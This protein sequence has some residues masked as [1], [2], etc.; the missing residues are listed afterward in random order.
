[1][2]SGGSSS[3]WIY[4]GEYIGGSMVAV[5]TGHIRNATSGYSIRTIEYPPKVMVVGRRCGYCGVNYSGHDPK[6]THCFAGCGAAL[7]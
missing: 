7:P 3:P 2:Y 1:M 5:R 4:T 6:I